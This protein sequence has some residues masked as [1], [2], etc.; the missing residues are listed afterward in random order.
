MEEKLIVAITADP[1]FIK[2]MKRFLALLMRTGSIGHSAF[3]GMYC[4]GDGHER[5][6]VEGYDVKD[7]VDIDDVTSSADA[8]EVNEEG[9]KPYRS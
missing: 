1:E 3:Y 5:P 6:K 4:D 9:A 7:W 8:V 2:K